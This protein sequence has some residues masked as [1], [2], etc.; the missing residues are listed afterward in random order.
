MRVPLTHAGSASTDTLGNL[1][2][3]PLIDAEFGQRDRLSVL[4]VLATGAS[5]AKNEKPNA[6]CARGIT[7]RERQAEQALRAMTERFHA[8]EPVANTWRCDRNVTN[9]AVHPPGGVKR[10]FPFC[11]T[12]ARTQ[13]AEFFSVATILMGSSRCHSEEIA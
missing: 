6:K 3:C 4:F 1:C 7:R 9:F 2:A 12:P 11:I 8:R 5:L 13:R 10:F